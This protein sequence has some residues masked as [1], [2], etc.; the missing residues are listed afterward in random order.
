MLRQP[1][2]KTPPGAFERR[3]GQMHEL[4]HGAAGDARPDAALARCGMDQPVVLKLAR[5]QPRAL[6][7][8]AGIRRQWPFRCDEQVAFAALIA[9]GEF[10]GEMAERVGGERDARRPAVAEVAGGLERERRGAISWLREKTEAD[11]SSRGRP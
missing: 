3:I 8:E 10:P 2:R 4:R 1:A 9:K 6:C 5:E 11:E 7:G